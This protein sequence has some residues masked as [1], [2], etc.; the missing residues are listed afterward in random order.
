MP[1]CPEVLVHCNHK[2][3]LG[4]ARMLV[5]RW[6]GRGRLLWALCL[7][8]R[9]KKEEKTR[10]L[11]LSFFVSLIGPRNLQAHRDIQSDASLS[12]PRERGWRH[13]GEVKR[14]ILRALFAVIAARVLNQKGLE[15]IKSLKKAYCVLGETE[16]WDVL[17][18]K[19]PTKVTCWG[20][21]SS[22]AC[23]LRGNKSY[24]GSRWNKGFLLHLSPANH[25]TA[26]SARC[27]HLQTKHWN[28]Q[29]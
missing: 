22:K 17:V 1:K 16:A 3:T 14:E 4:C 8:W 24:H 21:L 13:S 6:L 25:A 10:T 11:T 28:G 12:L 19:A 29:F 23:Y 20:S 27:L 18:P 26:P 2:H 9:A 5:M 15:N 7:F